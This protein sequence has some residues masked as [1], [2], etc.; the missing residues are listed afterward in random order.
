MIA[1]DPQMSLSRQCQLV[2]LS[3]SSF[4][5]RPKPPSEKDLSLM[6]RIDE[7][8]TDNPDFGSRQLRNVLDREGIVVNRKRIQRLM[9]LM[10]IQ[11]LYPKKNLSK[12]GEGSE[13]KIYPYLLRNMKIHKANQVW[14]TDI[15][16]I[17]LKRGFVYLVAVIDWYSRKILSWELS[18]TLEQDFCISTYRRAVNLWGAPEILNSD[19]GSQF[20]SKAYRDIVKESKAKFSM[21]GKGRALDNIAI[22]RFWRTLKYGE[23]YLKE[24]ESIEEAKNGING[25]IKKYNSF[26]PHT[27]HGTKTPDEVYNAVA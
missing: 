18:T 10:D 23:I 15:T 5:Y 25:F 7:I 22:E 3:R 6:A 26:R 13:H 20:T 2:N 9:R 11:A 14:A 19:Q 16:Y 8:Y 17:R 4:Y 12:P 27:A 24:Y 21:D 1:P